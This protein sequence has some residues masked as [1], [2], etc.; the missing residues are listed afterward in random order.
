M[1][2]CTAI[3]TQAMELLQR[4]GRVAYRALKLQQMLPGATANFPHT[5]RGESD[6][7]DYSAP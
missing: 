7:C 1:M 4:E 2:D 6:F 5:A 3:H